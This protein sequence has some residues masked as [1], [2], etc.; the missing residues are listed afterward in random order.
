MGWAFGRG[1]HPRTGAPRDIG[2]GVRAVCDQPKCRTRI[3]RGL[4]YYCGD[5]LT[6]EGG[7]DHGC[8][9]YFCAKHLSFHICEGDGEN[10]LSV[11]GQF[12]PTCI[13]DIVRDHTE[14]CAA[15]REAAAV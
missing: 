13:A 12:C 8:G 10:D 9:G 6:V 14:E 7:G 1:R 15:C 2:Y 11:K 3:D 5:R 4:Y